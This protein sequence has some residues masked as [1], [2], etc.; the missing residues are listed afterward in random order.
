VGGGGGMRIS[1]CHVIPGAFLCYCDRQCTPCCDGGN[2]GCDIDVG[3]SV[4]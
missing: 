4:G 1:S 3:K 2:E